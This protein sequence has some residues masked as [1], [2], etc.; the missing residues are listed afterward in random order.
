MEA[1]LTVELVSSGGWE[2]GWRNVT[3]KVS[4]LLVLHL[5][6]VEPEGTTQPKLMGRKSVL[7]AELWRIPWSFPEQYLCKPPSWVSF[8]L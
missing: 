2:S 5:V 4:L 8:N 7:L 3:R 1:R 6:G